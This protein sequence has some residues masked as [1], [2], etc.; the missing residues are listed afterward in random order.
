ML[1]ALPIILSL[2]FLFESKNVTKFNSFNLSISERSYRLYL[3]LSWFSLQSN[4]ISCLE[5]TVGDVLE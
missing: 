2:Y 1:S 3:L 4:S 5:G